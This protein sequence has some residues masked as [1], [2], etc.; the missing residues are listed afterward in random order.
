M[1]KNYIKIAWRNIRGNKLFTILNI[2]GLA[3]GICVCLIL[4]AFVFGELGFDRMYKNSNLIYR[5]N[6]ETTSE[7]NF[8]KWV[9]L[10][11]SVGPAMIK[12]IPEVKM[13]TRLI[14]DDFGATASLKVDEKNF[15][16]NNLYLA[17]ASFFDVFDVNFLE[18]TSQS[19]FSNPNSVVISKST[20]ERIFG[21]SPALG[22]M[23]TVNNRDS[24]YVSGIYKDFP[25]NSVIDC[26]MVYNILDSWMGKNV[27]WSNSSYETY[28]MLQPNADVAKVQKKATN[29][30]N[31]YVEKNNQFFTKFMLQPLTSIHLYSADLRDG[32]T[33]RSGSIA[34]VKSL[35]FLALLVLCI[36][37]INYMNLSTANSQKRAKAIGVN[38]VL[39][40]VKKQMLFLC[41]LETGILTFIAILL[42]YLFAFAL[43]PTFESITGNPLE[44]SNLYTTKVLLSLVVIWLT[45]TLI[46]GSYPA[47]SMASTS[48][49]TLVNKSK[50]KHGFANLF[51]KSL[52]IFQFS[53]SVILIIAVIIIL[54]Q[55]DFIKKKDLG[56]NP[57]R[58]VTLSIKSAQTKQQVD[59]AIFEIQ[60]LTNVTSVSAVQS[61]P[62]DVESG[63]SVT[64]LST[65]KE[66]LPIKTCR[67]DASIIQTMQLKLLAGKNLP[68]LVAKGDTT[69]YMLINEQIAT[70]LGY[71]TPE[72]AVGKYINAELSDKAIIVGVVKDFNFHSLKDQ[73]GGYAYYSM[74]NGPEGLRS[75]LVR[76]DTENLPQLLPQLQKVFEENL[77]NSAFDYQFL[78][79]HVENLYRTEQNTANTT[80]VFSLLAIFIACLGLFGLAAFTAEQ[81][82]KEIGIR[83]VLGASVSGLTSLLTKNFLKLVLISFIIASP[84][85]WLLMNRWLDGFAY[86]TTI[87]WWIFPLAGMLAVLIALI[88]IGFQAIKAAVANPVKSLRTE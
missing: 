77:P 39:G 63:R 35:L 88:T 25:K 8:E 74:N 46:A 11:N 34:T 14:K 43:T 28:V 42:G 20:K 32:Y 82:K 70:Y 79:K 33:S 18:G 72:A 9:K 50:A 15:I 73:V 7:Y 55:M 21:D 71:K 65:D 30:I 36:A 57:N 68:T 85:A 62:G 69:C 17:D 83:K 87:Q 48:P 27:Y 80:T 37:C 41:Y 16:E 44:L 51:R 86:R 49:L 66:G 56:Y 4:F 47:F 67:T 58:V 45:V 29:L 38:K 13:A 5:V 40:A 76:Y 6:M 3:I 53:A 64:K 54:Q 22:K 78:D 1:F 26:D 81:R 19:V 60:R 2:V 31:K 84:I 52:V 59:R 61:I 12:D 23:I 75:L 24:L 10:P